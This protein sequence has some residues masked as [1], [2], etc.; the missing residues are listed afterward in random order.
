M[1]VESASAVLKV[2]GLKFDGWTSVSIDVGLDALS[3]GF[4]LGLTQRW[5]GHPERWSVE[6]GDACA[7]SIRTSGGDIPLMTGWVDR[8]SDSLDP[9]R[10]PITLSGRER[11]CDLV[12]CSAIH[13]P[14][15][16]TQRTVVQIAS[17][18]LAP[19]GL[20]AS[21]DVD[22][23]APFAR[24][25]L[26]PGETVFEAI[27][28]MTRQRGLLPITTTS[29]DLLFTR[30]AQIHAGYSLIEGETME[31][32]AFD[33]DVSDRFSRYVLKGH[34]P[35][36]ESA[37]SKAARPSAEALDAGVRRHRPLLIVADEESTQATLEASAKWE[38]SVRA[39]RAQTVTATVSGWTTAD[40]DLYRR[41]V[42]VPVKAP[43]LGLDAEMLIESVG[44]RR[45]AR[46]GSTTELKLVLKEAYSLKPIPAPATPRRTATTPPNRR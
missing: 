23:G 9:R 20:K 45:S 25:A 39:G 7:L 34:D 22:V 13:S 2:G 4:D 6:P 17:D 28:R 11:T 8:S 14:G 46:E 32:C 37:G 1:A 30:P 16:W 10:H 36:D 15:F 27:E 18:L 19:F 35:S 40:G 38:A 44:F 21:A 31:T 5:P 24:F 42:L 41:N 33:N 43:T 3:G 29:G 26:E 12:D